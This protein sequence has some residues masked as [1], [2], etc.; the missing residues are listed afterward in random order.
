MRAKIVYIMCIVLMIALMSQQALASGG[1]E[2]KHFA[3][4]VD[5][6]SP[7]DSA[8]NVLIE[9]SFSQGIDYGSA[10]LGK[11]I[12][13]AFDYKKFY[14]NGDLASLFQSAKAYPYIT[15][16]SV[17]CTENN[18][19]SYNDYK[20]DQSKYIYQDTSNS[21]CNEKCCVLGAD[22]EVVLFNPSL[23]ML[24][25]LN[26]DMNTTGTYH[27]GSACSSAGIITLY[28]ATEFRM[29]SN[30]GYETRL[31][32][33]TKILS[34]VKNTFTWVPDYYVNDTSDHYSSGSKG[35]I[36]FDLDAISSPWAVSASPSIGITAGMYENVPD[37]KVIRL[38][39]NNT[40]TVPQCA[41]DIPD[42]KIRTGWTAP[43]SDGTVQDPS[44]SWENW[45]PTEDEKATARKDIANKFELNY[46]VINLMSTIFAMVVLIFYIFCLSIIGWL[47]G[48]FIPGV[49]SK[50]KENFK[51][52]LYKPR[53]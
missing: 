18:L 34:F 44:Q 27:N 53:W 1:Y 15:F 42:L 36:Y 31:T 24:G 14:Y 5:P 51:N 3:Y 22:D 30:Q 10:G 43:V 45:L 21:R 16:F 23:Q 11:S 37:T 46:T 17:I 40:N 48:Q 2:L 52:A 13:K 39:W 9:S 28:G 7:I 4:W 6:A 33:W 38:T 41:G 47:F 12:V 49:F 25:K 32:L 20:R 50:I 35:K 8:G 26:F 19:P 29:N